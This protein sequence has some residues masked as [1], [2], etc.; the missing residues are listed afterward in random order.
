MDSI[1]VKDSVEIAKYR[2]NEIS[3][4]TVISNQDTITNNKDVIIKQEKR[5]VIKQKVEKD[6]VFFGL[7]V[8][9]IVDLKLQFFH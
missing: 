1:R 6:V 4:K 9:I 3:Y 8:A 7:L 5:E 2:V